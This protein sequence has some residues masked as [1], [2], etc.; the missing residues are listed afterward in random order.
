M[1]HVLDLTFL[2]EE[3]PAD[4]HE[5]DGPTFVRLRDL[6]GANLFRKEAA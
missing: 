5:L 2:G 6:V 1:I 3:P 4:V